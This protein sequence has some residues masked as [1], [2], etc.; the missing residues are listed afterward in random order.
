M[1]KGAC[2]IKYDMTKEDGFACHVKQ[3]KPLILF[4]KGMH[5]AEIIAR[6]DRKFCTF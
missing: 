2:K 5:T 1:Q 3:W 6:Q 4:M